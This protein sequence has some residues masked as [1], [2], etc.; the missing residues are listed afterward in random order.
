MSDMPGAPADSPASVTPMTMRQLLGY[1]QNLS[2]SGQVDPE[3]L[4]FAAVQPAYPY[5]YPVVDLVADPPDPA[6]PDYPG[7]VYLA[8]GRCAGRLPEEVRRELGWAAV[9]PR[10][11]D[12]AD[13]LTYSYQ[14]QADVVPLA[15]PGQ[16][17]R[18]TP[19]P[20]RKRR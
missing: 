9:P 11:S 20:S 8:V 1:L 10:E 13:P 5:A 12:P 17:T 19:T 3:T 6:D 15:I 14:H 7:I 2:D 18:T 4:V 16:S